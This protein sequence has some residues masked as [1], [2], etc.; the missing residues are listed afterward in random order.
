MMNKFGEN[1]VSEFRKYK[2]YFFII[3]AGLVAVYSMDLFLNDDVVIPINWEDGL[4]ENLTA[5]AFFLSAIVFLILAIRTRKVIHLLF[6][7]VFLFGA[8]EEIS[9]GQRIFDF[10][11]PESIDAI[12]AQHEF[13]L[14]NLKMFES[15][16]SNGIKKGISRYLTVTAFYLLFCIFYG[17]LLPA[18]FMRL[19]FVRKIVE[20]IHLPVPPLILGIFF[21]INYL[22]FKGVSH[23]E[24]LETTSDH[25]HSI[26][27]ESFEFCSGMIFLIISIYFLQTVKKPVKKIDTGDH[28]IRT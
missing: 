19:G 5:L 2:V 28:P 7:L 25:F 4:F 17:V 11:T 10:E 24:V 21:L 20:R 12:N 18:F 23:L 9:W 1:V 8:G 15:Y 26:I 14:H 27:D 3:L 22:I 6:T 16:D 13:N